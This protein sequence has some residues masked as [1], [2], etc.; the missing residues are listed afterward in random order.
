M[1]N[2]SDML[3]K[4]KDMQEKMREA[5]DKI[6]KIEVEGVSGGSLVKVTLSGDYELKS[7]YLVLSV[8]LGLIFYLI[9]SFFM[10]AFNYKD[11]KLKY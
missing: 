5:Q 4:A 3:S 9:L 6:K 10:K 8:L 7:I 1:T 11:L 2:F